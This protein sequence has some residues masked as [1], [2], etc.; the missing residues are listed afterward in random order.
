MLKFQLWTQL[1]EFFFLVLFCSLRLEQNILAFAR[2]PNPEFLSPFNYHRREPTM[3]AS[4]KDPIHGNTNPNEESS[5]RYCLFVSCFL[6][7]FGG[8]SLTRENLIRERGSLA[9]ASF[10]LLCSNSLLLNLGLCCFRSS[11]SLTHDTLPTALSHWYSQQLEAGV[12][13]H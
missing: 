7:V 10:N 13:R 5:Y 11:I 2:A 1:E 12:L 8:H 9:K 6:A 4:R 3:L